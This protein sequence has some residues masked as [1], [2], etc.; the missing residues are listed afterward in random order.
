MTALP[1]STASR[2]PA[3]SLREHISRTLR[4]AGPVIVARCGILVMVST[5]TIM[6]G[7]AGGQELAYLAMAYSIQVA[8]LVLGVGLMGGA[9]ILVSQA[10][11]AG[12][13]KA[14]GN[15]LWVAVANG[16]A[17]GCLFAVVLL[18]SEEILL[19]FGQSPDL[20]AGGGEAMAMFAPGM[21]AVYMFIATTMF[22]EGLSRP[23]P[24]M[25]VMLMAIVVNLGLNWLFI[26]DHVAYVPDGA[27][28]AVLATSLTRWFMV[29]ALFT[30][31][32]TMRDGD[33]FGVRRSVRDRWFLEKRFLRLGVPLALSYGFETTAFMS[34]TMMAG[35]L[36]ANQV[37]GFQVTGNFIALI[38]M[39]AIGMSAATAVRVGNAVGRHDMPGLRTAGW[40]GT[41]LIA[42]IMIAIG[43]LVLIFPDVIAR[44][45]TS[46]S[47]VLVVAI[48][49]VTLAAFL[50]V[51]DGLQGVLIG[52]LRGAGDIWPTTWIGL[53]AFW[54]LMVPAGYALGIALD[55]KVQGLLV[56]ELIGVG[57]ASILLAWRFHVISRRHIAPV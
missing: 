20:A 28:G 52:A 42:I 6:T 50:L 39:V 11:G 12:N 37:A 38:F 26:Y 56:A 22:L 40:V 19:L 30:Y 8:M 57:A 18:W 53:T 14:C 15:I 44:I 13:Q 49:A 27:A 29:I 3:Q 54:L 31:V 35:W 10:D 46:D 43:V 47:D 7:H 32:L 24:G 1:H 51:A 55:F 33:N 34:L 45:Y 36:G 5:D 17:L 48:P 23:R 2:P 21:P 16:L 9:A 25:V 4:L 41:G